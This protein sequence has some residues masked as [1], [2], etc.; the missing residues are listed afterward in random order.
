MKK[1]LIA[2]G[3]AA[4]LLAGCSNGTSGSDE[5][6]AAG[7]TNSATVETDGSETTA[8]ITKED[9][10]ITGVDIDVVDAEGNSKKDLG[11]DYN[12]K[13]ASP[14]GKEWY[15]Q[16]QFLEKYIMENGVDAVKLDD[17][18]YAENEDVKSG[19]TINLTDIMKAVDEANAK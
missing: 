6:N 14:I 8:T 15:E 9:G 7:T 13:E 5:N 1:A 12:M 3:A 10:K 17:K 16:V 2:F 11:D 18:G 4:L 19:C